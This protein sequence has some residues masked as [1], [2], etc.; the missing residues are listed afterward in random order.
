VATVHVSYYTDPACPWS[1][2]LEPAVRRLQWE[3]GDRL[4]WEYVMGGLARE[5]GAADAMVTDWLDAGHASGMPVDPRLWLST[6]LQSSY[7]A[8]LA[9]KA[10][11]EQGDP[12][13]L[14]RRL[15]EA[16]A[17]GGRK[18]DTSDA[19]NDVAAGTPALDAARFRNDLASHAIVEAFGADLDRSEEAGDRA[20][21][22]GRNG[23]VVLPSLEFR[24]EDGQVHGVYGATDYDSLTA[25]AQAAGAQPGGSGAPSVE[26]ALRQFGSMATPEVAAVCGL[27]GP[28]AAAELWRLATEWAV[29]PERRGSGELWSLIGGAQRAPPA[30]CVA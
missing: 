18:L 6:P 10:A 25:A 22:E 12:A 1:W 30:F 17:C 16:I 9:V 28:R 4:R 27:P 11:A 24:G 23:R 26:Q 8:C 15:R 21:G 3:F 29:K 5:F 14:L 13:R 19:L 7:P 2:A 20:G